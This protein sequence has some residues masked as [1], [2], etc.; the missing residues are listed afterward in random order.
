MTKDNRNNSV[1]ETIVEAAEL[2]LSEAT[3][4]ALLRSEL[5]LQRTLLAWVRTTLALMAAGIAYDK[6]FQ[7]LHDL[8][9][10]AGT[11]WV[12][13]AHV[14]GITVIGISTA[15]LILVS[16]SYI[17]GMRSLTSTRTGSIAKML[18][19][20]LAALLVIVVG[21]CVLIVLVVTG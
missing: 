18:P 3:A 15:L 21:A 11:A 13:S 8:R 14:V 20:L 7:Y 1:N 4:L 12:Q 5:A 19:T 2:E 10:E 6:G 16:C 9:L 17:I